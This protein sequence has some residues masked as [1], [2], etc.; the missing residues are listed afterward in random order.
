M[1][2]EEFNTNNGMENTDT[3]RSLLAMVASGFFIALPLLLF[4]L[5]IV[6]IY[7]IVA[8]YILPILYAMPG[9]VFHSPA[10]RF[11]AIVLAVLL[12]FALIGAVARTRMGQIIGSWL[13]RTV[14]SRLPYYNMVRTMLSGLAGRDDTASL[15]PVLVTVDVPGLCQLGLIVE[16]HAD[17]CATVYLPSSP[18]LGSGTVVIVEPS[19]MRELHTPLPKLARCLS[20]WGYGA[21]AILEKNEEQSMAQDY[22]NKT[23]SDRSNHE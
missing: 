16:R 6:K 18:N 14:L 20:R 7:Q 12:L 22:V 15:K 3:R 5:V 10:A 21:K 13:E 8:Q 9:T 19:R 2:N 4:G 23:N 17:G 1:M 11:I